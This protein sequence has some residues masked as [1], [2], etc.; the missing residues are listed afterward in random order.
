MKQYRFI[1][2]FVTTLALAALA[3]NGGSS[4][5]SA[6]QV[7]PPVAVPQENVSPSNN[8]NSGGSVPSGGGQAGGSSD[9]VT[10]T[11]ANNLFSFDLPGDW[12]YGNS[13]NDKDGVYVDRFESPD[14]TGFIENITGFSGD[15]LTGGSNGKLALYFINKY[16]SNT[17]E[18][19]DIRVSSDQIQ[20]D[21]SERL[22]WKSTGG[23][24]SGLSYFEVRGSDRKTFL[25]LTVWWSSAT[26]QEVLDQ[27]NNAVESYRVP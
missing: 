20:K 27:I 3:C 18:G 2:F 1:L 23:G 4:P 24:Y 19:G 8:D 25:M 10:F 13:F 22:A 9:I 15:P 21:G 11:D 16:Y 17:G 7:N 26:P 14:G 12:T 5:T 6:P